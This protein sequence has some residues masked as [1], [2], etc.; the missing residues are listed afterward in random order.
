[1]LTINLVNDSAYYVGEKD[2]IKNANFTK[3]LLKEDADLF[4]KL[5]A[6]AMQNNN[7]GDYLGNIVDMPINTIACTQAG[8]SNNYRIRGFN[9]PKELDNLQKQLLHFAKSDGWL[10]K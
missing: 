4:T 5:L 6:D 10:K 9:L 3:K 2:S 8:K 1:M 7:S